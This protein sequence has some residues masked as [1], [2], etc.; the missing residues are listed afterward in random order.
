VSGDE[1]SDQAP[2]LYDIFHAAVKLESKGARNGA[3]ADRDPTRSGASGNDPFN[4][5]RDL[6]QPEIGCG[7]VRDTEYVS[8]A[9]VFTI[10]AKLGDPCC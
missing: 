5:M 2:H 6:K 3:Y 10:D 7:L 8:R 1:L 4:S 9:N